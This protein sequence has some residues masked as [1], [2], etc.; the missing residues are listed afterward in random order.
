MVKCDH[1]HQRKGKRICPY[2]DGHICSTCCGENRG[3][4]FDCPRSCPHFGPP[5]GRGDDRADATASTTPASTGSQN[6]TPR[7]ATGS[8][9]AAATAEP[10]PDLSRYQKYLSSN[11]RTLADLMA[12]I[13]MA[14]AQFDRQRR[15]LT[16]A[17]A[18]ATLEFMR[19]RA[20]PITLVEKFAPEMGVFL[21]K[22]IVESYHGGSA[23]G[24]YDLMEVLDHLVGIARNFGPEGSRRYLDEV[25]L[26]FKHSRKPP[27]GDPPPK[28]TPRIIISR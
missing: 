14:M 22:A 27:P 24:T 11:R 3:V 21:E 18:V 12:R 10:T 13:E 1:C 23:P 8:A 9:A 20:S 2:L 7:A 5:A 17:D 15:G 4:N 6:P 19:R 25:A 26:F 16:D 28:D